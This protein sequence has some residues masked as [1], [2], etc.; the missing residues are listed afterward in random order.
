MPTPTDP[1]LPPATETPRPTATRTPLPSATP[2]EA[3]VEAQLGQMSLAQKAGQVILSGV[4]GSAPSAENCATITSLLPGGVV[5]NGANVT[6]PDGQRQ[7]SAALQGCMQDSHG[8]PLLVALDHEGQFIDRFTSGATLF[9]SAMAVGASQDPQNAYRMAMASGQELAYAGINLVLG[10]DADVLTNPDNAVISTRSYGGD[11]AQASRFAAQAVKG[12]QAAGII[13]VLKH[14]PGHGGV[15]VDSHTGLP[16]DP[17]SLAAVQQTQLVPF[18][19][20]IAAGADAV[21]VGHIAYPAIDPSG[22]PASLS[23]PLI[24]LLTRT[25]GFQGL[26]LSDAMGMGAITQYGQSAASAAVLALKSGLD[27]V[28]VS[29][30]ADAVETRDRLVSAVQMGTFSPSRLDDAVRHVLALKAA[31]NLAAYPLSARP[32]PDWSVDQAVSAAI[33]KSA[34]SLVVN[35]AGLVPLPASVRRVLVIGPS[36][37]A[38]QSPGLYATLQQA[39]RSRQIESTLAQYALN[40]PGNKDY[41]ASAATYDLVLF[42]TW[43]AHLNRDAW[44][45]QSVQRLQA[46]GK[47]LVVAALKSP[48]DRLDFA[49]VATFLATFGTTPGQVQQ[50]ADILAG[51]A[52]PQGKLPV[53]MP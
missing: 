15:S 4:I 48:F 49:N 9:P 32:A 37:S 26:A 35:N 44:Q 46:S 8:L 14:F 17:S 41:T 45:I 13:P 3:W 43:D 24:D 42:L 7:L 51:T 22:A 21:M 12:Y 20:G 2:V 34:V 40:T 5:Y 19:D 33:G 30:P 39:L 47:P 31:H 18:R 53:H 23:K 38:M 16:S 28:I 36:E 10:P 52:Q 6:T 25:L 27:M 29:N 11:P 50:L 1:T